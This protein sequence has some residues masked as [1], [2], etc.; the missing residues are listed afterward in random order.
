MLH[1]AFFE[2]RIPGNTG[3]AI[4]LAAGTGAQVWIAQNGGYYNPQSNR[5]LDN[6]GHSTTPG[7]QVHIWDCNGANAQKWKLG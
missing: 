4:R 3:S 6:P 2:P 1:V 7:T 5:C